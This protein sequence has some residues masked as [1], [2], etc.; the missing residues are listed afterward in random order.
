M[1]LNK[2][3]NKIYG[4]RNFVIPRQLMKSPF[5]ERKVI[6][7]VV[8]KNIGIINV[9]KFSLICNNLPCLFL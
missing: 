2:K 4:D 3:A 9:R 7:T 5:I 8:N 6:P 1:F